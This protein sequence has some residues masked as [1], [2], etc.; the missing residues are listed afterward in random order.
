MCVTFVEL[1]TLLFFS[2]SY[3][4]YSSKSCG[5]VLWDRGKVGECQSFS[6]GSKVEVDPLPPP[7][8]VE[9]TFLRYLLT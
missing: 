1:G 2:L 8:T 4:D 5:S 7:T 3:F 6:V 9:K